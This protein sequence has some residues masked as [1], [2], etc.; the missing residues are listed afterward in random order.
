MGHINNG[1]FAYHNDYIRSHISGSD[2]GPNDLKCH[3]IIVACHR[4][5]NRRPEGMLPRH[6]EAGIFCLASFV[7]EEFWDLIIKLNKAQ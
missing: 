1:T 5:S 2:V 4:K 3:G 6:Q 7:S